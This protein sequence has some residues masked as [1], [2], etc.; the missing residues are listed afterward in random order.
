MI[1]FCSDLRGG[2]MVNKVI[3]LSLIILHI[4]V[5]SGCLSVSGN[6]DVESNFLEDDNSSLQSNITDTLDPLLERNTTAMQIKSID[7]ALGDDYEIQNRQFIQI[8]E[9]I[10][11]ATVVALESN[12]R[13]VSHQ[14]DNTVT[15][16]QDIVL[17]DSNSNDVV[18]NQES[19]NSNTSTTNSRT[20]SVIDTQQDSIQQIIPVELTNTQS[21]IQSNPL[22][23]NG[24]RPL[25]V[26][27]VGSLISEPVQGVVINDSNRI[28][29]PNYSR[30][31]LRESPQQIITTEEGQQINIVMEGSGWIVRAVDPP[32][33]VLSER[34]VSDAV[35]IFKFNAVN[36]GRTTIRLLHYD[37]EIDTMTRAAYSIKIDPVNIVEIERSNNSS[38]TSSISANN[39]DVSNNNQITVNQQNT[40]RP[41][42]NSQATENS[43]HRLNLANT[44]FIQGKFNDAKVLFTAIAGAGNDDP[45]IQFKLGVCNERLGDDE[46]AI[47]NYKTNLEEEDNRYYYDSLVNL[48]GIL[49]RQQKYSEAIES[50]YTYALNDTIQE[51]NARRIFLL[52]ADVYFSMG[53]YRSAADE[54]RRYIV[55]FEGADQT[56]KALF[57][58]GYSLEKF[59]LNP[60]YREAV[61]VYERLKRD[62]PESEYFR[63]AVNRILYI[64]RHYLRV[65]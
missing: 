31:T 28:S 3:K 55:R 9:N 39:N 64:N 25:T 12:K 21:L 57:Y 26:S 17:Q 10:S 27:E 40:N 61:R 32:I 24:V 42:N 15:T 18:S 53:E 37:P 45:D 41:V 43:D 58:L 7:E 46:A 1:C 44:L 62:F 11:R 47:L 65:N 2:A 59:S 16:T 63:H 34:V 54:Y 29:I 56:D 13:F 49:R 19:S 22:V 52:L 36:P 14:Q 33:A 30:S 38:S 6:N 51:S 60:D 5:L 23:I 48:V 20:N 8:D 50:I 4:C 35:T